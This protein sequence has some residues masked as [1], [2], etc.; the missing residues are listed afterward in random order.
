VI[1]G[2]FKM[3]LDFQGPIETASDPLKTD[4]V[5]WKPF[6]LGPT[7][8]IDMQKL[9]ALAPPT[10]S[11]AYVVMEV[12]SPRVLKT[13]LEVAG[14]EGIKVWLNGQEVHRRPRATEP[15]RVP[16]ELKEGTNRLLVKVH[17]I[18]GASWVWARLSDPERILEAVPPKEVGR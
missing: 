5:T 14:D 10:D 12:R 3:A 18:Y 1:A 9:G 15:Q 13:T 2:P 6:E 4:G 16:V 7:A 11:T 8:I 17:N